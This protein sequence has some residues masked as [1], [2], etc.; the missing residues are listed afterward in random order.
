MA[1]HKFPLSLNLPIFDWIDQERL[2]I[3][4]SQNHG[5]S[6]T[7]NSYVLVP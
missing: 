5:C 4:L 3:N 7:T 1:M 6:V 2:L